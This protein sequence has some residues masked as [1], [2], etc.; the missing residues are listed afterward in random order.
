MAGAVDATEQAGNVL[1]LVLPAAA[2]GATAAHRDGT[3]TW[4]LAESLALSMGTT[5]ALKYAVDE[6]RPNGGGQAFPSG[7]SAI[8]VSSAEFLRR[9]YGWGFGVPAYAAAGFVAYSRVEA[10]QHQAHDVLAGA[11]IGMLSSWLFTRPYHGWEVA[12]EAGDRYCGLRLCR[13]W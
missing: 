13:A 4:Q 11:A 10:R 1:Q 9:R 7:H 2:A 8:A 3:G 5:Y 6:Q 12:A